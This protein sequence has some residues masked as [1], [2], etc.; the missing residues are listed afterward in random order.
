MQQPIL[1]RRKQ[2]LFP[3]LAL[4]LL[5]FF[6][7]DLL[8]GATSI[9]FAEI[10]KSL[11]G[12]SSKPEWNIIVHDFRLPKALAA[13]F[14]GIALSISGLQMQVIFRNPLAGPDVLGISSGASLGVAIMVLTVESF[15][16]IEFISFTGS[17]VIVL[18][19]CIGSA[20]TMGIILTVSTRVKD[21]L[22]VLIL[23]IMIGAAFSSLVS[24]LQYFGNETLLKSFI[25]WTLGSLGHISW[26]QLGVMVPVICTGIVLS[27]MLVKRMNALL[28]GEKYAQSVGVNLKVTRL[29]IFITTSILAGSVTAFCGPIAFIA[30]AVPHLCRMM[31]KTSDNLI[32][33]VS[34]IFVGGI[35]LLIS[36]IISQL[37]GSSLTLPINSVTSLM[38]IPIVIWIIVR[39]TRKRS[40]A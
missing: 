24:I 30:I 23:G 37:P 28:I 29:L 6:M 13:I 40:W 5:F 20:I 15:I 33:L 17:W 19:A 39:N 14:S 34:C 2:F 26:E 4:L 31:F 7:L 12:L 38:G 35:I 21:I 27:F 32:L 36:D 25:V 11:A 1:F 22:T 10:V 18:A 9:P 3:V 8:L 16:P